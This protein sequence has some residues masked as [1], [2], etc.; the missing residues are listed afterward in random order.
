MTAAAARPP[1]SGIVILKILPLMPQSSTLWLPALTA[2]KELRGIEVLPDFPENVRAS[3][4]NVN[5]PFLLGFIS[6]NRYTCSALVDFQTMDAG[7]ARS[8]ATSLT[9]A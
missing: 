3:A 7:T 1:P 6:G 4:L 5:T 9:L 8:W 2:V